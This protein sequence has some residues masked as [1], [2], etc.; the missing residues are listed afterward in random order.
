MAQGWTS[1]RGTWY[2]LTPGNGV[3]KTG[4]QH[5]GNNWFYLTGSGGDAYRLDA[6]GFHLVLL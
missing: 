4:W 1:V 3:M 6:G 5:I 2:Y